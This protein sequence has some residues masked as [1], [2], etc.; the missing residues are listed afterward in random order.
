MQRVSISIYSEYTL[1]CQTT[2]LFYGAVGSTDLFAKGSGIKSYCAHDL[3]YFVHLAF[4]VPDSSAKAMQM[5]ST[6]K[7]T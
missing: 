5:K 3:I 6:V 4:F 1:K 7:Y 2:N